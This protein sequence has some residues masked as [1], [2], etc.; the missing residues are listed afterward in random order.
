MPRARPAH[1]HMCMYYVHT[2]VC[3]CAHAHTCRHVICAYVHTRTHARTHTHT[4]TDIHAHT[5]THTRTHA[6][7]HACMHARM[8][9]PAGTIYAINPLLD[10]VSVPL[11][12]HPCAYTHARM[13]MCR[14][15]LRDQPSA[16]PG[17]RASHQRTPPP[18]PPLPLDCNWPDGEQ[19]S[20]MRDE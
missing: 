15:H 8:C 4:R 11:H 20:R 9:M 1:M 13:H 10:L 19:W 17:V 5:H 16:R 2:Y 6:C 7:M 18:R 14:D 3:A 12:V